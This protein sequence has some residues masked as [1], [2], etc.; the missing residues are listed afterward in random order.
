MRS[1]NDS[2][3]MMP[4]HPVRVDAAF[5]GP[6]EEILLG[7]TGVFEGARPYLGADVSTE[8]VIN[9]VPGMLE[10]AMASL[11]APAGLN[12]GLLMLMLSRARLRAHGDPMLQVAAPL[13]AQ[14]AATDLSDGLPACF[15]R[16]PYP[17]VYIEFARPSGLQ[18]NHRRSGL[19]EVEGVYVGS[20]RLPPRGAEHQDSGR[21]RHLALDPT[22]ETRVVELTITG[23][24]VGKDNPLDDASVDISLYI[25]DEDA[26]LGTLLER[27]ITYYRSAEITAAQ[28][29]F[30]IP[31][32]TEMDLTAEVIRHLA[33]VL[34]Y[35]NLPDA[36]QAELPE[37]SQLEQRLRGL[38]P[39]KA[40]RIKRRMAT[41]YDRIV[42]GPSVGVHTEQGHAD[43]NAGA[44]RGVRPH[45][46]RGH[47]RRIR[48]G[49]QRSES[50]LGWI[51]P[52][53]VNAAEA[54]G[55]VKAKPYLMR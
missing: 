28:P 48:Y 40:A 42:I 37:R 52:V 1:R 5:G 47:F 18:I 33:K 38:G 25:Q 14:L 9:N 24:P 36:E 29:G 23:S 19:H 31:E 8:W 49:E 51:K 32:Q 16:C 55:A 26:C 41:T 3:V 34:L 53:L 35:L 44:G 4:P 54:F 43:G 20:Y 27:H 10:L 45:W 39:K 6:I 30:E 46:R 13:H 15:F 50:R 22:R 21:E 2:G 11:G 7:S 17:L 12:V